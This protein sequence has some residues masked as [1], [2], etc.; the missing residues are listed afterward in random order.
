MLFAHPCDTERFCLRTLL[1]QRKGAH[2]FE[3]MRKI[4]SIQ[5]STYKETLQA[6]GLLE[7]DSEWISCLKEATET[8]TNAHDLR[9]LFCMII[10]QCQANSPVEL[11]E[12]FKTK[13]CDDIILKKQNETNLPI[14]FNDEIEQNLLLK[15]ETILKQNGTNLAN[16]PGL[17]ALTKTHHDTEN[18]LVKEELNY[19]KNILHEFLEKNVKML[20]PDQSKAFD[21]IK[22]SIENKTASNILFSNLHALIIILYIA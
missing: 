5:Y 3:D 10:I 22:D 4:D 20:N 9:N 6:L 11:Y 21:L 2:S 8:M 18:H 13:L 7:D 12:K 14:E 19:D 16:I 1:L 17:P 15:L